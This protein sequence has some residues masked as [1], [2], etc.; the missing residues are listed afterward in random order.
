M[1]PQVKVAVAVFPSSDD[2][3]LRRVASVSAI[4]LRRLKRCGRVT[5]REIP[6]RP[7]GTRNRQ[8]GGAA[9]VPN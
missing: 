4:D 5:N 7:Q 1:P 9:S 6:G 2:A 3:R 8:P